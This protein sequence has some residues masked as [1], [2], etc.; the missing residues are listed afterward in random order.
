MA[1]DEMLKVRKELAEKIIS[2]IYSFTSKADFVVWVKGM[3]QSKFKALMI[4]CLGNIASDGDT[5]NT[6]ALEIK[7]LLEE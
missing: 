5:K 1:L 2:K 3:T 4:Q 6:D 7:S